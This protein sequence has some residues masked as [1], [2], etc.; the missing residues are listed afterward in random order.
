MENDIILY[1][2]QINYNNFHSFLNAAAKI[3]VRPR[4]NTAEGVWEF[5]RV[6]QK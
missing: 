5:R 2:L 3:S 1:D 4:K 6:L